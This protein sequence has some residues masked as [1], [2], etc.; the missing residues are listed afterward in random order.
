MWSA[1]PGKCLSSFLTM[2]LVPS[3]GT[4][5]DFSTNVDLGVEP[6]DLA[7]AGSLALDLDLTK[8]ATEESGDSN[9]GGGGCTDSIFGEG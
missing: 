7:L 5:R 1:H 2:E 6:P 9:G 3:S 4:K 8:E